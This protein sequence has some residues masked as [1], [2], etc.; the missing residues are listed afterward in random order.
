[1]KT[2][3]LRYEQMQGQ[4]GADGGNETVLTFRTPPGEKPG[5]VAEV[6]IILSEPDDIAR[7]VLGEVYDVAV[8]QA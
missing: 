4:T 6:S 5:D 3:K 2:I 1:M 7:Y 8:P